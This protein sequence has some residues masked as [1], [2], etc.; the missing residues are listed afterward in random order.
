MKLLDVE[1]VLAISRLRSAIKDVK[2]AEAQI[3]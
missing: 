2:V 1:E 3:R